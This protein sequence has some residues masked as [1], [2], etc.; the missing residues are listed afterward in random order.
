METTWWT[1]PEQLDGH[2]TAV[3]ALPLTGNHLV[4]G[5][6]GSGKTNLLVLRGTYLYGAG[7]QNIVVMTFGRVLR[8]FLASGSA[9]YNFP[10]SKI[11]TYVRW[12]TRLITEARGEFDST[13]KFEDIRKRL[14]VGLEEV[15]SD[16]NPANIVDCI[17]LDEAQDYSEQE[18]LTISRFAKQIF[19]VGDNRQRIYEAHGSIEY[20]RRH[21]DTVKELPLQ[22]WN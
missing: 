14:Q 12:A 18:I 21:V 16:G 8:E 3:V 4:I 2:Q 10:A 9:N 6:P 5:P 22:E 17:L 1:Q 11:Q 13:G 20:L 7:V 15:A 19:A